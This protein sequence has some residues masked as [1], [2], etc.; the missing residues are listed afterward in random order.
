MNISTNVSE[1]N[2][3]KIRKMVNELNFSLEEIRTFSEYERED[4]YLGL[5]IAF[6]FDI[7]RFYNESAESIDFEEI[8]IKDGF[9]DA[10][11]SLPKS[12]RDIKKACSLYTT[13]K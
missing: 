1:E 6:G 8:A 2:L 13:L 4:D 12:I 7:E 11:Y 5:S 10:F 9:L 3:L